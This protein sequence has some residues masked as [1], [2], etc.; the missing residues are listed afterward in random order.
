MTIIQQP[1]ILSLSRNLKAF[2]V[3]SDTSFS[4]TLCKGEEEL[5]SQVYSPGESGVVEIDLRD[6]V[7]SRLSFDF[8]D[9]TQIYQQPDLVADFTATIDT[10]EVT[11]RVV[12]AGVDRLADSATNFLTQ[13]F[14][15][16]QPTVKPVTYYSPEYL[17]YYAVVS[18]K[19]QLKAYFTD[20]AGEVTSNLTLTLTQVMTGVAYTIPMQ[21]SVIVGKL[22]D[23]KPAYYDVWVENVSGERLTYIQ[24]YYADNSRSLNEDWVLFEN[25]LGGLDCFRAYGANTLNVEHTHNIAETEEESREYRVDTE[26]KFEKN[27]GLLSREEARW[28]LD[29]FPSSRKYIYIGSYVRPIVVTESNVSGNLRET[30]TSYTFTYK[31]A[32]ARP[33]LNLP[34]TDVPASM[35]GI[36][37]PD[38]GNFTVPPRLSEV[39]RLSLSEGALF[40]VQNPY[41]ETWGTT[42]ARGIADFMA[43]L[44]STLYG[45]TGGVGHT[46]RNYSLLELLSYVE[47][48]LLVDGQKINAGYADKAGEVVDDVYLRKDQDDQTEHLIKF[49]SGLHCGEF[50]QGSTGVGIYQDD[51][52]NWHIETDYLDVRLKFTAKEVE[53]QTVYHIAGAQVKSSANMKCVRVEELDDVYR[54]YM[55]T[56]DDDGNEVTNDFKVQ[57]QAYVQTFN[58]VKQADGTTG[59]HFLWRLVVAVGENYI[60][61]S[62]SVCAEGSDAPKAGDDIVQLGYRGTDDPNRQNAVIDAGAGN[63]SPYYRQYVGIDS[64][65]LP[66]PE[67]QLK[68]GDNELSGRFHIEQGSTGWRNMDGLPEEI[69][70]AMDAAQ[71]AQEG[72]DSIGVGSVNLLRNSGFTGNYETE[73]LAPGT[74]LQEGTEMYSKALLHWSGTAT[75]QQDADA[76]SGRSATVGSLSQALASLIPNE[77]Y[78][79]SYKAKGTSLAVSCGDFS[80]AQPLTTD[81]RRYAHKFTFTGTGVFLL[82][83]IAT[84]CDI[85]LERGTIATD[86]ESSPLDNDK[87]AARFQSIQYIADAIKNG[88]VDILGGLI[89]ASMLQLGNYKDGEMQKVTAGISG[90]YNDDDDVYTWGGGTL[91]QAIRAVMMFKDDPTYQPD[92]AELR[93]IAKAVITHG[94][95]AILNDVI[96]RG[97]VYALGGIFQGRVS[98]AG[99]KI[100][101][102]E[103]GSGK[104]ANG[105]VRWD[106]DGNIYITGEYE[107]NAYGRK[108]TISPGNYVGWPSIKMT[109]ADGN[110][111]LSIDAIQSGDYVE[112][113]I[114]M[115]DPNDS[116]RNAEYRMS[117]MV[118]NE[119]IGDNNFQTFIGAGHIYIA[120]N[121]VIDWEINRT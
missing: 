3:G 11:F 86:W 120:K 30:P 92:E 61:L 90:I 55:N 100:L 116:F 18:G 60:D 17:T 73:S 48:Y 80:V 113:K 105:N 14:L 40:P 41:S 19:V 102:D 1:D 8:K 109:D 31:Y 42:T 53:I 7:H 84:V 89:L 85:Q 22:G 46:H 12:R 45:T 44:L 57:D 104:L 94:G 81:Y 5:L 16:W 37:I 107:S 91:E 87:T 52:G 93:Q 2:L 115:Q 13:N 121:S 43:G 54:C 26:R 71:A 49:L 74:V 33:L 9:F 99:G 88:S 15:T 101:L 34:R 82:S 98:I 70:E 117:S 79:I 95:R 83:G 67:T 103:D 97:Y 20:A 96:L 118:I 27:T 35:L 114:T 58:L 108:I 50:N 78:V 47:K 72:V 23:K 75:V 119:K 56:T 66:A 76:V 65:T 4:F 59:N 32:D 25:S 110:T 21:Y 69:Q 28:L 51:A 106:A 36:V 77:H 112:P 38:I 39:P 10:Q 29:F 6:I 64:F 24:R 62:K 111:L 68:P 63:G